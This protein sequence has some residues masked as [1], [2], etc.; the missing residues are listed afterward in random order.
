MLAVETCGPMTSL[1]DR[2]RMGWQ[3]FGVSRSGAMDGLALAE[4]NALVGNPPREAALEFTLLG[5]EFRAVD[6][7]VRV[8]LA[9]ASMRVSLDGAPL[10]PGRSA[11]LAPG[12]SLTIGPAA[13][14]VFGYLAVAGGF[15]VPLALGSVSL[16]PRAGLGGLQGRPLRG[17]DCLPLRLGEPPGPDL[18]LAPAGLEPE[19]GV[20]VVLGPQDDY[21]GEEA[22]AAF[23]GTTWTVSPEADRMGYR[24]AGPALAH[25]QGYNIV[26]DGIVA[27]SVQVPGSGVPIV[28]MADHQTTGGYPKIATVISADLRIVAQRPPGAA[29]R[30][31]AVS[32]ADAQAAARDRARLIASL[33][34]RVGPAEASLPG[35]EELLAL[36]LAG[37][38]ADAFAPEP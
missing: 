12:R 2:G 38:A 23:L 29:L 15:D 31:R 28:M 25:A 33:P 21:F 16:H 26:S 8:A 37:A 34:D 30:F 36:N 13:A 17:G 9:G 22:I 32:V 11:V 18:R 19:A 1:Q 24:L 4:A 35:V 27:G 14:G 10:P 3:R 5:G 7:S 6:G 20:R